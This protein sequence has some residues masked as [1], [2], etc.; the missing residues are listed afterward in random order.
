M[1]TEEGGGMAYRE[2]GRMEIVEVVR[3]WQAGES[4]R[5]IGRGVGL[6]RATVDKYVRAAEEL[7]LLVGGMG[8]T[9]SQVVALVRQGNPARERPTPARTDLGAHRE[10]ISR[11]LGEEHLRLTRVQ[12]LL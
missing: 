9:E 2:I 5:A 3:R 8:P 4:R 12:E 10:Q 1:T 6:A 11:W 7:G